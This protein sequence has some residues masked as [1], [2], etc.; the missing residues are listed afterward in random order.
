MATLNKVFR[1]AIELLAADYGMDAERKIEKDIS[2][3]D[4]YFEQLLKA[5]ST[6]RPRIVT[7]MWHVDHGK[8]TLRPIT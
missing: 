3:L 7:I 8:A 4:V 6:V 2:D 5:E 1:S